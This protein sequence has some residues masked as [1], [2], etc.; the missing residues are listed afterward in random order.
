MQPAVDEIKGEFFGKITLM[1]VRV[2]SGAI[3]L[4]ADF[5][6]SA[7]GG[8]AFKC[9]HVGFGG[10]IQEIGV[11]LSES[12]IAHENEGEFASGAS[13]EKATCLGIESRDGSFYF[14]T[15]DPK[16]WVMV[17]DTDAT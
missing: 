13:A 12:W 4:Y 5:T 15:L 2:V 7:E 11:N 3:C 8:I 14:P 16:L 9:D 6:C 1:T 10:I 17:R